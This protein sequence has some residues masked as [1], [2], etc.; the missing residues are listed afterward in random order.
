MIGN[1]II[2]T[3]VNT[4]S[5][6]NFEIYE[7]VYKKKY[8]IIKR[9]GDVFKVY[10]NKGGIIPF[11]FGIK[12][13]NKYIYITLNISSNVEYEALCKFESDIKNYFKVKNILNDN[14]VDKFINI[15]KKQ[16]YNVNGSKWPATL[17]LRLHENCLILDSSGEKVSIDSIPGMM[18]SKIVFEL[19]EIYIQSNRWGFRLKTLSFL[20]VE[21]IDIYDP[22]KINFFDIAL[23]RT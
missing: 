1:D 22:E 18:W 10:L 8:N 11:S 4:H 5:L 16:K 9:N 23:Q 3:Y 14:E 6:N 7:T 13:I 20:S 12:E 19:N 2:E 15:V 17:R 21:N